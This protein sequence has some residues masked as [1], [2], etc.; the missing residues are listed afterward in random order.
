[1]YFFIWTSWSNI[2]QPE[3][4]K[5]AFCN[6]HQSCFNYWRKVHHMIIHDHLWSYRIWSSV[7]VQYQCR[8]LSQVV[9]EQYEAVFLLFLFD[10]KRT[11][12]IKILQKGPSILILNYNFQLSD[13]SHHPPLSSQPQQPLRV[14]WP[15][16]PDAA[17]KLSPIG[18]QRMS[19]K[20]SPGYF[21]ANLEVLR[22]WLIS[23]ELKLCILY[24]KWNPETT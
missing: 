1:M 12:F 14:L 13:E 17:V 6:C 4:M 11:N 22:L 9:P 24:Q 8:H 10:W 5:N 2:E 23:L 20:H 7:Y 19:F 18:S 15:S 3:E 16:L 21:L